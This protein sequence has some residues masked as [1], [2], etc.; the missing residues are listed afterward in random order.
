MAA[1]K[2]KGK[3][4]SGKNT[5][6]RKLKLRKK[7]RKAKVQGGAEVR[8][9]AGFKPL[10]VR[11]VKWDMPNGELPNKVLVKM[12]YNDA[13]INYNPAALTG[14]YTWR[15]NSIYAPDASGTNQPTLFNAMENLY[16]K[17]KVTGCLAKI[18][19]H[20]RS[21]SRAIYGLIATDRTISGSFTSDIIQRSANVRCI[22]DSTGSDDD[23]GTMQLYIPIKSV[24]GTKYADQN[25]TGAFTGNPVDVVWLYLAAASLDGSNNLTAEVTASLIYYVE[26]FEPKY[27][28]S[29]DQ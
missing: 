11:P 4:P 18:T 26:C 5:T 23:T 6:R 7:L 12:K 9:T 8:A 25:Y 21:A 14:S 2:W 19:V 10:I 3:A 1:G 15:A 17:Y 29:I 16:D 24:V 13:Y 28:R 20:N 27:D 22:V